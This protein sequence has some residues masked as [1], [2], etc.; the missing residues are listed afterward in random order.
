MHTIK[1]ATIAIAAFV[2]STAQAQEQVR[3]SAPVAATGAASYFPIGTQIR[4]VTRTELNTKQNRAGER[5]YL[6]VAEPLIYRGQVVVPIGSLAVGELARA[7]RNGHFGKKGSL[8]LRLRYVQTPAGPI[9]LTGTTV[10]SGKSQ[11]VLS[12]GGGVL[13]AWPMFFIHGTSGKLPANTVVTAQLIDD[14]PFALQ[15]DANRAYAASYPD[16]TIALNP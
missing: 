7:E 3:W 16:A 1:I 12:V 13:V 6:D 9:R 10:R 15:P 8:E 11:G 5:V 4:L 14:L 2:G